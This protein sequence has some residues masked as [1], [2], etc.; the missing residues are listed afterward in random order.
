MIPDIYTSEV[1]GVWFDS[2]NVMISM[3]ND[4]QVN[5]YSLITEGMHLSATA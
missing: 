3:H 1:Y 4:T 5:K 2:I